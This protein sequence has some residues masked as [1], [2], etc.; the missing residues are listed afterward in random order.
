M[1]AA[2]TSPA[3]AAR[4]VDQSAARKVDHPRA[5][6]S[7]LFSSDITEDRL[8]EWESRVLCEIS[9]LLWESL[10]DFHRSVISI[11][12]C[13]LRHLLLR[14]RGCYT[15]ARLPIVVPTGSYAV[16]SEF[17]RSSAAFYASRVRWPP[18][19]HAIAFPLRRDDRRVMGEAVEQGR[20]EFFVAGEQ[21]DPFGKREIR[22]DHCRPAFVPI[23]DQIKEQLTPDA[24]ER[25]KPELVDDQ[26]VDAVR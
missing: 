20:R 18:F 2:E 25:D 12:V 5:V 26:D 21:G 3:R 10:C 8:W 22:G 19:A 7:T 17:D 13:V 4:K 1:P 6:H 9:K 14:K 11:A 24:V 15:L 23:G 16:V